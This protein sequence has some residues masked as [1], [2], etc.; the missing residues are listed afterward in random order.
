MELFTE[1]EIDANTEAY[2]DV[3]IEQEEKNA[4]QREVH[5]N[6]V[7]QEALFNMKLE[8]FE[9]PAIKNS[10]DKRIKKLIRKAK[11]QLE[12]QAWVTTLLQMEAMYAVPNMFKH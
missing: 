1:E 10:E 8:A 4:E 11:T 12:V 9:I 6:R 3:V 2:K 5:R 7:M